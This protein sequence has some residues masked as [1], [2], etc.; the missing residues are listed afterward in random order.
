MVSTGSTT[1]GAGSTGS[2]TGRVRTRCCSALAR[3]LRS[4]ASRSPRTAPRAS[5]RGRVAGPRRPAGD[6]R[7]RPATLCAGPDDLERYDQVFEAYFN[8]RDGLPAA[9]RRSRP[10]SLLRPPA[11]DATGEG[12]DVGRGRAAAASETEVLRHRD[13]ASMSAAERA[14]WRRCSRP[15]ARGR[16]CGVPP[17]TRPGTAATSTPAH[18]ARQPR[19]L[20]E[21][22]DIAWRRRGVRPRR[23]A[24]GGRVRV[25]ERVRRPAAAARAPVHPGRPG[26]ARRRR[27]VHGRHPA[28]LTRAMRLRDSERRWWRRARPCRTGPAAPGSARPCASSSTA[29]ASAAWPAARSSSSSATA[30]SA[31]TRPPGRADGPAAPG[32]APRGLGQPA[33]GQGRL[34]AGAAGRARGLAVH[35]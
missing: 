18:P 23:G 29:G 9:G 30:G 12:D 3:A 31:A 35:R 10:S 6:V 19:R 7:R 34:R 17:G 1:G 25:D 22:A 15:S 16:R 20:G 26:A 27:D 2:T 28:H 24:A 8:A 32:R 14:A 21:P 5:R 4:R 11:N 13:V 33:P